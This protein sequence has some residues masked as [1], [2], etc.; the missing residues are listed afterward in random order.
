MKSN[1]RK[2]SD[3]TRRPN[4]NV[5]GANNNLGFDLFLSR[6]ILPRSFHSFSA[7]LSICQRACRWDFH[8]RY[9]REMPDRRTNRVEE[10]EEEKRIPFGR[11]VKP[12]SLACLTIRLLLL[13]AKDVTVK[14]KK[15]MPNGA[16]V[17]FLYDRKEKEEIKLVD[18]LFFAPCPVFQKKI[19]SHLLET[20]RRD[21]QRTTVTV[22][23]P[24]TR[25]LYRATNNPM[26][27]AKEYIDR[28]F[29]KIYIF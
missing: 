3:Q 19:I 21:A 13:L 20:N 8:A 5:E 28:L 9:L 4:N 2:L 11:A 15:H 26:G 29:K 10:E 1:G 24:Y 14:K 27:N 6:I 16:P 18:I 12:L 17:F 22:T 25:H 23:R 7:C